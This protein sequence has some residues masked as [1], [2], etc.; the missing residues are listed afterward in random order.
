MHFAGNSKFAFIR[1]FLKEKGKNVINSVEYFLFLHSMQKVDK[2]KKVFASF[3]CS[4]SLCVEN[5][6]VN[7]ETVS[8]SWQ[9]QQQQAAF[10]AV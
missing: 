5:K 8:N 4:I 10:K 6:A 7:T 2:R 1:F 3:F 9:Q